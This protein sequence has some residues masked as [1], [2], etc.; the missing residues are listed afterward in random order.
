MIH[1]PPLHIPPTTAPTLLHLHLTFN[2]PPIPHLHHPIHIQ[3]LINQM[4]ALLV[5]AHH[6]TPHQK[7]LYFPFSIQILQALEI[8][9]SINFRKMMPPPKE[10]LF[11]PN[12]RAPYDYLASTVGEYNYQISR[13]PSNTPWTSISIFNATVKSI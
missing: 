12:L 7:F 11:L 10:I 5:N 9:S 3:V 2:R 1:N 6:L 8:I 4:I 13:Q